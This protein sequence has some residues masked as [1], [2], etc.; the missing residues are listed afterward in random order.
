MTEKQYKRANTAVFPILLAVLLLNVF[1]LIMII[2]MEKDTADTY[3]QLAVYS[4]AVVVILVA[5]ITN[6]QK[7][8]CAIALYSA[9]GVVFL[10]MMCFNKIQVSF[11][12][13]LPILFAYISYVNKR[14]MY[15]SSLV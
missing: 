7:R 2:I 11:I 13:A 14:L 15:L 10:V 9:G 8:V 6:R 4:T 1:F 5:F 12:Y 3:I